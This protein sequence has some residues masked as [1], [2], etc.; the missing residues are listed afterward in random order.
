MDFTQRVFA[1][2]AERFRDRA[3]DI[4][5]FAQTA[6]SFEEWCN[7]EAL[8]ACNTVRGWRV[9]PKP[10]YRDCGADG[11]KWLG[12]LLITDGDQHVLVEIGLVHD[13]TGP[14][15][16]AKLDNDMEKLKCRLHDGFATLQL[17][18]LASWHDDIELTESWTSW[19]N[20]LKC[21][22][23][24]TQLNLVARLG[25]E[26]RLIVRGWS[27]DKASSTRSSAKV[28]KVATRAARLNR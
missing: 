11:R 19:L 26:G 2:I 13:G 1:V 25:D 18:V 22:R 21:W 24:E 16:L 27:A 23:R 7:W 6:Y 5:T 8:A 10:R 3:G 28:A 12:D 20:R 4:A 14:K 17:I 15:W 9:Q